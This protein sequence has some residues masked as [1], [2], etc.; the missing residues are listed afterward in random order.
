MHSLHLASSDVKGNGAKAH[1]SLSPIEPLKWR[2]GFDSDMAEHNTTIYHPNDSVFF[3]NNFRDAKKNRYS[4]F[5]EWDMELSD[6]WWRQLG[7]RAIHL[8]RDTP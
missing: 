2:F 6:R 5:S 3:V 7:F 4:G 8:R 1:F